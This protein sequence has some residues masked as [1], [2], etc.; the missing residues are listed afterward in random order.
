MVLVFSGW[1][2]ENKVSLESVTLRDGENI[3][4]DDDRVWFSGAA[5]TRTCD[6]S[7]KLLMRILARLTRALWSWR[8][9]R[10]ETRSRAAART[11]HT[12]R[13]V[14]TRGWVSGSG[15]ALLRLISCQERSIPVSTI[16][17]S[18]STWLRTS[19]GSCW[20]RFS[21]SCKKKFFR[22]YIFKDPN[23]HIEKEFRYLPLTFVCNRLFILF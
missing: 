5:A 20:Y 4:L 22:D 10:L 2:I 18:S 6:S 7:E 14:R 17:T 9:S 21:H 1:I 16:P 11:S 13:S 8:S 19:S 23:M 3:S 15:S 12:D